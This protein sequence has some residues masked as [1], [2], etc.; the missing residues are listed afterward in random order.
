MAGAGGGQPG[1]EDRGEH[2]GT[3]HEE[4]KKGAH[5]GL[6]EVG[7]LLPRHV[8]HRVHRPLARLNDAH[9]APQCADDADGQRDAAAPEVAEVVLD[10]VPDDRETRDHR[11][12]FFGG[13]RSVQ[14]VAGK[15]Q[16]IP[17]QKLVLV[18]VRVHYRV[19]AHRA[20]EL[21]AHFGGRRL[22]F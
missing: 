11:R 18:N 1:E 5:P 16:N 15:Q 17:S 4:Q 22:L 3:Q 12:Y 6:E 8:P 9:A 14:A 13:S 21:M 2:A 20:A 7:P 10:V 19:T